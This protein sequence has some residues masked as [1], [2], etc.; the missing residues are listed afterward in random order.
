MSVQYKINVLSEL[1]AKGYTTTRLRN[2]KLIGEATIQRLRHN[3][4]V[5]FDVLSKLCHLLN[6]NLEDILEYVEDESTGQAE[7]AE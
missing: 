1:K 4:S 3:K 6:C 5:S 7:T 2:E